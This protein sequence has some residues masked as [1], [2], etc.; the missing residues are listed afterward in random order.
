MSHKSFIKILKIKGRKTDPLGIIIIIIIII[1]I[2]S[3]DS[4][5][6]RNI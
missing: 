5:H 1:I 2:M 6:S 4:N 3:E